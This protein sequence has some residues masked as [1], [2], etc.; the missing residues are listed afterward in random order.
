MPKSDDGVLQKILDK[1]SYIE[2]PVKRFPVTPPDPAMG[3]FLLDLKEVCYITTK[4]DH[5]REETMF[6]T[7]GKENYYSNLGLGEIETKLKEHPH[8]LRTSKYYIVNLTKIRG[9]KVSSARDLWFDGIKEPVA[10]AV[11]NTYL[12]EFEKR[13]K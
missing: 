2:P 9:L 6:K 8:F 5:G 12:G 1:L 11:T 7:A 13:L 3:I 10:N 4:S